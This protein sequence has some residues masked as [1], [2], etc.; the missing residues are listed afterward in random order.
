MK[1]KDGET[2]IIKPI[3]I[4][5]AKVKGG[6]LTATKL[7]AITLIEKEVAKTSF[8][9]TL[10]SIIKYD[11]QK[12]LKNSLKIVTPINTVEIKYFGKVTPK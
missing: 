6:V 9:T 3:I 8:E 1:I 5:R 11:F 7:A 10:D 2:V 4:T 12:N